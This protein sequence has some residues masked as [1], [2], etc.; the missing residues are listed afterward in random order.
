MIEKTH[1]EKMIQAALEPLGI[2]MVGLT[3][4]GHADRVQI[5]V[6]VDEPGG[7]SIDRCSQASRAIADYFDQ[8]DPIPSR[9]LLQVSSPGINWPLK[10]ARDYQR[11]LNRKVKILYPVDDGSEF[12]TII[13]RIVQVDDPSITLDVDG[14]PLVFELAKIAKSKIV[15]EF[16]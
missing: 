7:I 14:S 2:E 6:Y 3:V 12:Q 5:C 15:L 10:T 11:H 4:G 1:L 13:G 9:Y 16:K 8:E